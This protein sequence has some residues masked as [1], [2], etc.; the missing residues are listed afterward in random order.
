MVG[1]GYNDKQWPILHLQ[2][3]LASSRNTEKGDALF[4]TVWNLVELA[5]FLNLQ[6]TELFFFDNVEYKGMD[7]CAPSFLQLIQPRQRGLL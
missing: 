6:K 7:L 2:H 1:I 5:F 4:E 3:T